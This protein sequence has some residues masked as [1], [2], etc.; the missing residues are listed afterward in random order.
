[1]K[2]VLFKS[3]A[4][5]IIGALLIT[6]SCKK[7]PAPAFTSD[8]SSAAVGEPVSFT[9]SEA[10]RK[11]ASYT[12][13]FGDGTSS[14]ER[15][16]SHVYDKAGSY[17]VSHTVSLEKNAE[18]GKST[19]ASSSAIIEVTGPTANF[20]TAKTSYGVGEAIVCTNTTT[21]SEKGYTTTYAWSWISSNGVS[22]D[23]IT[24]SKSLA[25]TISQAGTYTITLTATQ[26]ETQSSK[27][28]DVTI[29]G[30][31]ADNAAAAIRAMI[32]GSW[33]FTSDVSDY[34]GSSGAMG[35]PADGPVNNSMVTSVNFQGDYSNVMYE[36]ELTGNQTTGNSGSWYLTTDGKYLT[37]SGGAY[38]NGT[39][40]IKSLTSAQMVLE[41]IDIAGTCGNYKT[42]RTITLDK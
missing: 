30:G 3:G 35:C 27:S 29:T 2:K 8:K 39:Y 40:L 20:T 15:N 42:V 6:S 38:A 12:W 9:D 11:N 37:Y 22:D 34:T 33:K 14:T 25:T 32:V 17:T 1:M 13:D 10:E 4:L 16:P 19:Q 36:F 41:S 26:G 23:F 18:E 7:E 5:L 21:T 24:S 31:V 28:M